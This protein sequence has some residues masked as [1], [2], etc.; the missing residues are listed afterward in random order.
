MPTAL[1]LGV[2]G[3][4]G[5]YLA[6]ALL[7]RGFSVVGIGRDSASRFVPAGPAFRY[8]SLDLTDQDGLARLIHQANPDIAF[9][10]AAVHGA[11]GSGF[12]YEAYWQTM[13]QVNVFALHSLLEHAR[14]A[15]QA[16]RIVYAGSAKVFPTPWV[17]SIDLMTPMRATCLYGIGK[18]AARDLLSQYRAM[19]GVRGT[20]LI[21]FNHDS[22]RRPP[23]FLLPILA[24]A[25]ARAKT[26]ASA[27]QALRTLNF[28]IDI[29][30]A[31]EIM[32]MLAE[33]AARDALGE[34]HVVASGQSI[35]ARRFVTDLFARYGLN[36]ADH[37]VE[38]EPAK[39]P[40]A[41]YAPN[42]GSFASAAGKQPTKSAFDI[43]GDILKAHHQVA[44]A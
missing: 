13:M 41:S 43:V 25:I 7:R 42:I 27:R 32:D 10:V 37:L 17:G 16:M 22:A 23:H 4:D 18:L 29:S 1:I 40:P 20:N 44:A 38:D 28:T 30:A 35:D 31:D 19:H 39:A 8:A 2:N 33:A 15:N 12:T 21:L 11:I 3:Q 24:A 26:D 5:S 6:E 14:T 34:E 9:H 36:A